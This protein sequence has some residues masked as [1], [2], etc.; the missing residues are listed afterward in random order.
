M[1]PNCIQ[2]IRRSLRSAKRVLA[3][4]ARGKLYKEHMQD[5][6]R[7]VEVKAIVGAGTGVLSRFMTEDIWAR[8]SFD[9]DALAR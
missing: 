9:P 2:S 1:P 6:H 4:I 3:D 8:I 5:F 7:L